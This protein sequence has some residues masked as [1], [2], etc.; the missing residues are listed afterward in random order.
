[1][2]DPTAVRGG[3][4]ARDVAAAGVQVQLCAD[5]AHGLRESTL[6]VTPANFDL[7][8]LVLEPLKEC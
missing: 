3:E 7:L 8:E 6:E 1:M 2:D 5:P 4:G